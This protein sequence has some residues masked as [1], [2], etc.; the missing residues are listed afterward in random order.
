[1]IHGPSSEAMELSTR[2]LF[3]FF[4]Y[5]AS[6]KRVS[7]ATIMQYKYSFLALE[8]LL[9][10]MSGWLFLSPAVIIARIMTGCQSKYSELTRCRIVNHFI[11]FYEY[12]VAGGESGPASECLRSAHKEYL[13]AARCNRRARL[14]EEIRNTHYDEVH[15]AFYRILSAD[16]DCGEKFLVSLMWHYGV[17]LLDC[18]IKCFK[19]P[20]RDWKTIPHNIAYMEKE[21]DKDVVV[22]VRSIYKTAWKYGTVRHVLREPVVV[23]LYKKIIATGREYVLPQGAYTVCDV[24]NLLARCFRAGGLTLPENLPMTQTRLYSIRYSNEPTSAAR[25]RLTEGRMHNANVCEAHYNGKGVDLQKYCVQDAGHEQDRKLS[26][27]RR[28][29]AG[30]K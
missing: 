1:M 24:R 29:L 14:E 23:H 10:C 2:R 7:V 13:R 4:Q 21:G 12:A 5:L 16:N 22:L 11:V 18:V 26:R 9:G 27:A 6:V 19:N 30:S 25:T 20:P 17:R 8:K 3:G 15:S 28:S